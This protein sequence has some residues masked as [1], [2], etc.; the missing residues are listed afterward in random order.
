VSSPGPYSLAHVDADALLARLGEL[1]A[2]EQRHTAALLAHLAE[3]DARR[4]YRNAAC[5]S[6]FAY[7]TEVLH[8]A[9]GAAYKRIAAARAAR[10]FPLIYDLLVSGQLHL[11]AVCLLAPH[12]DAENHER[13]LRS[14]ARR[15]RRQV[16]ELIA[17]H[18]PRPDVPAL[19]RRLPDSTSTSRPPVPAPLLGEA[20]TQQDALPSQS[21]EIP[22]QPGVLPP[23]PGVL[24]PQ[25]PVTATAPPQHSRRPVTPPPASTIS[26]LA[27]DRY[28]VQF[29]A[30]RALRDKLQQAQDLLR[31]AGRGTSD[32]PAVIERALDLLLRDA[33]RRK[34]GAAAAP[35][36]PRRPPSNPAAGP[37]TSTAVAAPAAPAAPT[38]PALRRHLPQATRRAVATRDQERC[39]FVDPRTGKRCT[40]TSLLH[41][42]HRKPWARGGADNAAN[43]SLYCAAHDA[44]Q[45]ERDYGPDLVADRIATRR[46]ALRSAAA[47]PGPGAAP[48][49]SSPPPDNGYPVRAPP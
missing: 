43:L 35:R 34:Y 4:L 11:T 22:P 26:P 17:A 5:A 39:A 7:C 19:I 27:P 42:H 31:G 40:A 30:S 41:F 44:L 8:Y 14:A 3:V 29:T 46:A 18:A 47:T 15:T 20:P 2:R 13:L 16:E 12:L 37:A 32:L 28:R 38:K 6:L 48:G 33:R 49:G 25:A 10:Q 24:P 45:A 9:E 21:G 23:Q 36:P 1:V